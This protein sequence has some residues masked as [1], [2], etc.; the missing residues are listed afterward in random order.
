MINRALL[1]EIFSVNF[2]KFASAVIVAYSNF[3]VFV[4]IGR[5]LNCSFIKV[6]FAIAM[7][8]GQGYGVSMFCVYLGKEKNTSI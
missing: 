5:H 2:L 6:I 8:Y 4:I 1:T 3:F 7:S